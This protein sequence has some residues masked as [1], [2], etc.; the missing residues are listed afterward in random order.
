AIQDCSHSRQ[1]EAA[2]LLVPAHCDIV[3]E[4][5]ALTS[6]CGE[7]Q[8]LMPA[9]VRPLERAGASAS[10]DSSALVGA[11]LAKRAAVGLTGVGARGRGPSADEPE[12]VV[13]AP[14]SRATHQSGDGAEE[15][16]L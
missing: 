5:L 6:R 13:V 1:L 12:S 8:R 16:P 4:T 9:K 15:E 2:F 11:A 7:P 3:L 10:G 14:T